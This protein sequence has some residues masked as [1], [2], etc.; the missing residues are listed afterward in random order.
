MGL[1][2]P[3]RLRRRTPPRQTTVLVY[4]FLP[5]TSPVMV[6]HRYRRIQSPRLSTLPPSLLRCRKRQLPLIPRVTIKV[7][8][9]GCVNGKQRVRSR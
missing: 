2:L 8:L 1:L 4:L 7:K 5:R 6:N 9:M 3:T